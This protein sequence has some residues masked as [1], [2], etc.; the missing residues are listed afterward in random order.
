MSAPSGL[1]PLRVIDLAGREGAYCARLLADLGADV[2]KVEPP[3]GDPVRSLPPFVADRPDADGSVWW[4]ALNA[5]KRSIVCDLASTEGRE[6]FLRLIARADVLVESFAPGHLDGLGLDDLTLWS[7]NDRLIH[8]SITPYGPAG[9]LATTPASDLE[10]TAMS[11]ALWLAGEPDGRPV[12]TTLPQ[13]GYWAGMYAAAGTLVAALARP[14]GGG[15]GQRVDVSSQA[16]MATVHAPA[17]L[18]WDLAGEDHG[19]T[20]PFLLGRSIVGARFRNVW[21]CQDGYVSFALQGGPIGRHTGRMLTQWM[22]ARGEAVAEVAAIDWDAWDPRTLT[23]AEVARLEGAIA[24]FFL[25]LTKA[26][27]FAGSVERNMLGYPVSTA[28]D[29]AADAQLA[30][31][32]F[33]QELARPDGPSLR[34]PGGFALFDGERPGL[35]RAAPRL[36][37]HDAEIRGETGPA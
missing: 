34:F 21:R 27:F 31:R 33:W 35:R 28:E 12:R 36:G 16:S 8:T 10:V 11:G 3:G 15:G 29:I 26:E 4:L 19:R 30:V 5:N 7:W 32:G 18:W 17:P 9:P 24:P 25:G 23:S 2:V 14:D 1:V 37:E 20:G 22:A 6:L 13:S